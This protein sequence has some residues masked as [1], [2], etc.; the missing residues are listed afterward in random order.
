MLSGWNINWTDHQYVEFL[1]LT[2]FSRWRFEV[3]SWAHG[4]VE[5][6]P[7]WNLGLWWEPGCNAESMAEE[8]GGTKESGIGFARLEMVIS[9]NRDTPKSSIFM[10][11]SLINHLS[12][13]T[14]ICGTPPNTPLPFDSCA[15]QQLRFLRDACLGPQN[16]TTP[17][18]SELV[19][20]TSPSWALPPRTPYHSH[21]TRWSAGSCRCSPGTGRWL[22]SNQGS[23]CGL[24]SSND[25]CGGAALPF[26]VPMS[27]AFHDLQDG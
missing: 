15:I 19:V 18:S 4:L 8:L 26:H 5:P 7:W 27:T 16:S 24:L 20:R 21:A 10:G 14:S 22:H 17:G 3:C 2:F 6:H 11:F 9:W 13:G 25:S 23:C 1:K 12:W